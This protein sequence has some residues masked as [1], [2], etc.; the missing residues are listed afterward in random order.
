VIV[1]DLVARLPKKGWVGI[2]LDGRFRSGL[3]LFFL[4]ASH[5]KRS[6]SDIDACG[7][8]VAGFVKVAMDVPP[9]MCFAAQ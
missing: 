5:W 7:I 1:L 4:P 8:R 9:G 3:G 2:G 6:L